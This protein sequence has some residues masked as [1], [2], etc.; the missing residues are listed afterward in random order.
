MFPTAR[1]KPSG[2][3]LI[4]VLLV[5]AIIALLASIAIPAYQ[6]MRRRAQATHVLEDLRALDSALDQYALEYNKVEGAVVAF[7]DLRGYLKDGSPLRTSGADLFGTPYGPFS[8]DFIPQVNPSTFE[9]LSDVTD[10]AFWSPF[11]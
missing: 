1:S 8:V 3:T 4:E 9:A 11:H 10:A 6:R 2:F 5:I 7:D